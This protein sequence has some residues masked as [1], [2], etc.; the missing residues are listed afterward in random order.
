MDKESE[1]LLKTLRL[2]NA[3]EGVFVKKTEPFLRILQL[4]RPHVLFGTPNYSTVSQLLR[5]RA[6]LFVNKERV[7][8]TNNKVVEDAFGGEGIVCVEDMIHEIVT[9]GRKYRK[10][11]KALAPFSFAEFLKLSKKKKVEGVKPFSG[12]ALHTKGVE[13]DDMSAILHEMI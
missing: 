5:K 3:Y 4:L 12:I 7:P 10:V 11:T 13:E 9:C 1:R 2:R 8:I 6:A